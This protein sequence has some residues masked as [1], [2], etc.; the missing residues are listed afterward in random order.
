MAPLLS[1]PPPTPLGRRGGGVLSGLSYSRSLVGPLGPAT[2]YAV[3][4]A[5]AVGVGALAGLA[6]QAG[7][8]GGGGSAGRGQKRPVGVV[9]TDSRDLCKIVAQ[10]EETETGKP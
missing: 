7:G 4:V 9:T 8:G 5:G 10:G 2:L 1:L 3:S 6:V